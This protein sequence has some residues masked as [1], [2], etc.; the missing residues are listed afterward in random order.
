V[1]FIKWQ[2]PHGGLKTDVI[3]RWDADP[4]VEGMGDWGNTFRVMNADG[5]GVRVVFDPEFSHVDNLAW[6]LDGS[7]L[8]FNG[9][10][11]GSGSS[12]YVLARAEEPASSTDTR[13]P[14]GRVPQ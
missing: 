6:S 12:V 3:S 8:A 7:R 9:T 14:S 5:S 4:Y 1:P 2:L 13:I 11:V 10:V